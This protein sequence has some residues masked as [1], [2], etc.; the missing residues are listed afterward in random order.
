MVI[1]R[2]NKTFIPT[3]RQ[4]PSDVEAVSHQLLMRAGYIRC[5]GSGEYLYLPL[6]QRVLRNLEQ[7]IKAELD[8]GGAVEYDF[9][10]T[11]NADNPLDVPVSSLCG[12]I[13]SYRQLPLMFYRFGTRVDPD[14]KP[15]HGLIRAREYQYGE[16]LGFAADESSQGNIFD[17]WCTTLKEFFSR[18][19]LE[20]IAVESSSAIPHVNKAVDLVITSNSPIADQD[21]L[22][23]EDG[24]Y[25]ASLDSATFQESDPPVF[26][27]E[28]REI[29]SVPTPGAS[30]IEDVTAFLQAPAYRLI[31]TL[32]CTADD[33]TV[34]V[35]VRGDRE[36]N[37]AKLKSAMKT[38]AIDLADSEIVERI[39]GCPVGFAGPVGL[40]K[41]DI[42]SDR[43]VMNMR[44]AIVG[45][46][47]SETHLINVN[48]VRDFTP[49]LIADLVNA[50][51][52]DLD[53]SGKKSLKLYRAL[54]L[55]AVYQVDAGY[56]VEREAS[57]YD[58]DSELKPFHMVLANLGISRTAQAV[59]EFSHD[60]N[61]L[62]WPKE[63]APYPV[64]LI[65]IAVTD[66][67][68][69][70]A[71]ERIHDDLTAEGIECLIDDRDERPGVKFNDADLIG[72][73]IRVVIGNRSLK[74]GGAEVK[75]R[76]G[77]ENILAKTDVVSGEIKSIWS[78]IK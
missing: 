72:I 44:N 29:A 11:N 77:T 63:I 71:S 16:I 4:A 5:I 12:E 61:G 24:T 33:R 59:A 65:P 42:I 30:T 74:A 6:M 57:F 66:E 60:D 52:G 45:A 69:R 9:P 32:I 53:P 47:R 76:G 67:A 40:K 7:L 1:M 23:S 43:L 50:E 14:I 38:Q 73:P 46:N 62:I 25:T 34:A 37:L 13:R 31:K 49:V 2:W 22:I 3:L 75:S 17:R 48:P 19:G 58:I 41:V 39:T 64:E 54:K 68:V 56:A 20:V 15:K 36:L 35:L 70:M 78:R 18:I 28:T 21:V 10:V 55:G 8:T 27:N 51:Q 26:D